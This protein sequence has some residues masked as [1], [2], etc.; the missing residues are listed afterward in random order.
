VELE[1]R[2]EVPVGIE[3]AWPSLLDMSQVADC[4]PGATLTSADGD[5]YTGSVKIK[6]GPIQLTYQGKARIV[7]ADES[8]HRAVIEA[9]GAASRSASTASMTVTATATAV[10]ED[11]T[12]VDMV[13]SLTITGRPAQFGR[14]VMVEVG[15]KILGQFAD[16]L[17][18][19]L[20]QSAAP[21]AGE[22]DGGA[23]SGDAG[24]G[25]ATAGGASAASARGDGE[26]DGDTGAG[27]DSAPMASGTAASTGGEGGGKNGTAAGVAP[28]GTGAGIGGSGVGPR[29]AAPYTR[30]PEPIDLLESAGPSI[31]KR[32]VPLIAGL[33]LLLVLRSILK[34][35]HQDD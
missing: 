22:S 21:A 29:H 28:G 15:N 19:K 10:A 6:L 9:S 33:V 8:T 20:A 11:R 27:R 25:D 26:G 17:S 3:S 1:H 23:G 32:V 12:A 16:C 4:F 7:E 13:T 2:F 24:S 30:S 35:R 31:V 18:G 34:H 5:E 14:G